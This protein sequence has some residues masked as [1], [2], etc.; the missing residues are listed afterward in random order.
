MWRC[1]FIKRQLGNGMVFA[2]EWFLHE[3]QS[4]WMSIHGNLSDNGK[5]NEK[6]LKKGE[7]FTLECVCC[8]KSITIDENLSDF[9]GAM[10]RCTGKES[11]FEHRLGPL[12]LSIFM[13]YMCAQILC[14]FVAFNGT[15]IQVN[16]PL[17]LSPSSPLI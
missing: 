2:L 15:V 11:H 16:F 10:W 3:T 7:K 14:I 17:K 5:N 4:W 8:S 13:N 1:V 9:T 6:H 12:F